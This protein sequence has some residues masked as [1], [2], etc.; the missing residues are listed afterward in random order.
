MGEAAL[1][2]FVGATSLIVG[3]ETAFAFRLSRFVVGLIMA[4]GVGALIASVSFELIEPALANGD[5]ARVG[6]G[7]VAGALTF[8]T[9]DVLI[10]RIGGGARKRLPDKSVSATAI[11]DGE[12]DNDGDDE[13]EGNSSGLGIVLG[14]V[15]DGI[16]ES[17]VLGLSLVGGGS[18]SIPL[19]AGIWVSNFP[20]ALG[21]TANLTDGGMSR[22]KVRLM[23]WAICAVSALAAG[24]GFYAV[25]NNS[26]AT[27]SFVSAFAA[28][29]LLTMIIDEM[30][31]EAFERSRMFAGL[32]TVAGFALAVWLGTFE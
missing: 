13:G 17:A 26:L 22:R 27:G 6:L 23:W 5:T 28:G 9:G 18:V 29:A 24:I 32:A 1:W 30:A 11:P 7:L 14:T 16:P 15:L 4:F 20:E 25:D 10:A 19:L 12:D 2:G 21:S 8:F 3:A 31:P